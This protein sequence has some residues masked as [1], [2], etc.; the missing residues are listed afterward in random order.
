MKNFHWVYL[1]AYNTPY[2]Y[3]IIEWV[4]KKLTKNQQSMYM[5]RSK[6]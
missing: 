1:Y 5:L 6:K 3:L 2:M 4:S